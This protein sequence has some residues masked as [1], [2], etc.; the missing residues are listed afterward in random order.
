MNNILEQLDKANE[1][2]VAENKKNI[3][4]RPNQVILLNESILAVSFYTLHADD[5][6]LGT[7]Y[8]II[9]EK[10][11]IVNVLGVT[12]ELLIMTLFN[13]TIFLI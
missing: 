13:E 1:T 6:F 3:Y 11:G 8:I 9:V 12:N 2:W 4:V 7:S 5:V 10:S